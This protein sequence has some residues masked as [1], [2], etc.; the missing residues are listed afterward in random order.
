MKGYYIQHNSR[1]ASQPNQRLSGW[2]TSS[3]TQALVP[4]TPNCNIAIK[5]NAFGHQE[6]VGRFVGCQIPQTRSR[7]VLPIR[8]RL[9]CA[10]DIW[11]WWHDTNSLNWTLQG[12]ICGY[13]IH[14]SLWYCN[15]IA[16]PSFIYPMYTCIE[17]LIT[18][19]HGQHLSVNGF[20]TAWPTIM[21]FMQD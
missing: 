19:H 5:W 3:N 2:H 12:I 8:D 14:S 13:S 21:K 18:V 17:L 16:I 15:V 4:T 6:N 20:A 10:L 1:S 7:W 11:Q 9:L